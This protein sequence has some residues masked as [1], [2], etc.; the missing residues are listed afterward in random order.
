MPKRFVPAKL[1]GILDF[2]T[3]GLFV[4]GTEIFGIKERAP[5]STVPSRVMG[6]AIF[7]YSLV[8]DYGDDNQIGSPKLISIKTHCALDAA[9]GIF[10]GLSPWVGGTWRKGWQYWAPQALVMTTETFFALTTK[11]ED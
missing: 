4:V 9:F 11:F 5:A 7:A 10:V 2:M 3:V 6:S 1:H 8:T